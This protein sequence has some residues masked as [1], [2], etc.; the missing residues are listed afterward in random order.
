MKKNAL[1]PFLISFLLLLIAIYINRNSFNKM[2]EYIREVNQSREIITSFE[3]VSND[4][5]SALIYSEKYSVLVEKEFYKL[6]KQEADSIYGELKKLQ[7]LT[8]DTVQVKRV[9]SIFKMI[10]LEIDTLLKYNIVELIQ[11]GLGWRL[12]NIF[13]VHSIIN[14]GI[15]HEKL[16][17]TQREIELGK[18]TRLTNLITIIFSLIAVLLIVLTYFSNVLLRR[19][20]I[21]L[22]EFLESV[23]NTSQN[24]IVSY[25]A[26][27][28]N[29]KIIDFRIEFANKSIEKLLGI[30]PN[31][32]IGKRL[33]ELPSYVLEADLL[34]KY[35]N[36]V[37]T[38]TVNE[39]EILFKRDNGQRW[40]YML[41]AKLEDGLTAT[42]HD[43]SELKRYEDVLKENIKKLEYS[44]S[45]LEQ[46]AY[47]ASHDLQEPLRKIRMYTSRLQSKQEARL[48]EKGKEDIQKILGAAERMSVLITDILSFSS[49][50][51]EES[52]VKI[53]LNDILNHVL[54]DLDLLIAQKEAVIEIDSLP[55]IEAIPLQMNQLF[56]NLLNNALK[57]SR[58]EVKTTIKIICRV[59]HAA[60]LKKYSSLNLD[61]DW[62]EI[63]F[64]DNGMGFDEKFSEQIFGI[65]K[66]LAD[67]QQFPGSGIGLALCRKVVENHNGI[68]FAEGKENVGASFHVLLPVKQPTDHPTQAF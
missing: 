37:E 32:I 8:D 12:K 11:A 14:R 62:I 36:V 33:S 2:K 7:D 45:E 21:W 57:F 47:A 59:P 27:R 39:F 68:L 10:N 46:Y 18:S 29:G 41:L 66:R 23:L 48:D 44:N 55:I 13:T 40:F 67:K 49:L 9:D 19:K 28:E 34:N 38:G 20:R 15:A 35:I 26:I 42:F 25:K 65:F 5:K 56:Y 43:I 3:Q 61:L 30:N 63:I 24:G 51:R 58:N 53:N 50:K 54:E 31:Q 60:E 64:R 4:F 1:Y 6:F 22:Q 52:Y 17:L 16:L